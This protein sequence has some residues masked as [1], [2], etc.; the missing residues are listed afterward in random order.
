MHNPRL[1]HWLHRIDLPT[2]L[3]WGEQD[4]IVTPAYGRRW[5]DFV[6]GAAMQIIPDAGHYPHWEQPEAFV[7]HVTAFA[8][9]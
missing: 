7:H 1:K 5:R 4:A 8:A 2:L 3:I 9:C 6:A